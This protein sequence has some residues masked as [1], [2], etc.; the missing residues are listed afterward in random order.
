VVSVELI[1]GI[2]RAARRRPLFDWTA[3]P[4]L[5]LVRADV[6]QLLPHR[7]PFLF[8]DRITNADLSALTI[9]GRRRIDPADPVFRGHF[10]G[11]PVYPGVLQLEMMGQLGLCLFGLSRAAASPHPGPQAGATSVRALKV[12]HALYLAPAG[13]GDELVI[14]AKIIDWNDY[15]GT[16][17][18]QL[19]K[20]DTICSF[21]IMEV[22]FVGA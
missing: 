10:P 6:E 14:L 8:V 12:H 13:P 16:C 5:D 3:V 17:V 15:T 2:V 4:T 19:L 1:D 9:V 22:Y 21:G 7:D 11:E 20:D 18:G